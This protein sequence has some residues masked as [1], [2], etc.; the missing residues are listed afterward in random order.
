VTV[1]ER[2]PVPA[3]PP[4]KSRPVARWVLGGLVVLALVGVFRRSAQHTDVAS[5]ARMAQALAKQ[6]QDTAPQPPAPP[7]V[8]GSED[9]KREL[10]KGLEQVKQS[11]RDALSD[12]D[13]K[14]PAEKAKPSKVAKEAAEP[15][16]GAP[17][18]VRALLSDADD[19]LDE[20]DPKLALRLADQSF[21]TK[22]TSAG[23]AIKARA[24][25]Q[26]KDLGNARAAL[27]NVTGKSA[28][29]KVVSDCK[30]HGVD[31]R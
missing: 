5:V 18:E 30:E 7:A 22:K 4:K 3:R 19:A 1:P 9:A 17:T 24:H 8:D 10:Q 2:Q 12:E 13:E 29:A 23:W 21:F 27:A 11:I 6:A 28:R 25:C 20:D 15:P 26:L 14:A 16:A 31:L